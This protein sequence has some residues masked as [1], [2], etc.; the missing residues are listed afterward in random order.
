MNR[1]RMFTFTALLALAG[2]GDSCVVGPLSTAGMTATQR[3]VLQM[4]APW[5]KHAKTCR[6]G[7]YLVMAPADGTPDE[8]WVTR[9][10][11][12]V[13]MTER[14]SIDIQ[15]RAGSLV[16]LQDPG[17]VGRFDWVSYSAVDPAD[18]QK[19]SVTD[20]DADG[21]LD[22]KIGDHAGFVNLGGEWSRLEKRG[23]QLGAIVAGEW[24]PIE[25]QGRGLFRLKSP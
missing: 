11:T 17:G 16:S 9:N 6:I 21:R 7:G 12:T 20:A 5:M 3:A 10:G 14:D 13:N 8:I 1:P 19:Y 2:C 4:E 22:T 18:G 25:K 23:N 15:S 24:R